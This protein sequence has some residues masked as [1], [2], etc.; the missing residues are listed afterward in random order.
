MENV[1]AGTTQT[2]PAPRPILAEA[3]DLARSALLDLG[4]TSIGD[5]LGVSTEDETAATHRF[6]ATMP[7]YRGWQWAVVLA[8]APAADEVTVSESVLLPGPDALI[9]PEWVPWDQRIRPGDLGPGDLLAPTAHD[10]RLVPGFVANG[11]PEIDEVAVEIG[12]GRKQVMSL[13]GR[14]D[15]A[16]RWHDGDYGPDTEM[17]KAAVSVCGLC[18]FYLPLA[19]SLHNAFGVCGNEFAMDGRVVHTEFGCGAH[20]DTALPT[21]AGSPAY[22]A[23]DDAA[24]EV[25]TLAPPRSEAA[26]ASGT[27]AGQA[28]QSAETTAPPADQDPASSP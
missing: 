3:V 4:E 6:A 28:A 24:V 27:D 1:S 16:Q 2:L 21:G 19:G 12:L 18:G 5:Y 10:E 17:A 25:V 14:V 22:A 8:A 26:A 20:S 15:A 9:A 11:D 23:F 13:D 7:G